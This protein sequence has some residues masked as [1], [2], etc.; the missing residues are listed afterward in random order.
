MFLVI[1]LAT[2]VEFISVLVDTHGV[3]N[4]NSL[5]LVTKPY[6]IEISFFI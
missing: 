4:L 2:H 1:T 3:D 5:V 6:A